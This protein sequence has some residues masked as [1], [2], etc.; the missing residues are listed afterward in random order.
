MRRRRLLALIAAL[1]AAGAAHASLPHIAP[2]MPGARAA[3]H[4]TFTWFGMKIYDAT[5]WVGEAGYAAGAPFALELRYARP[6]Q[7]ARIA[8]ASADQMEKTGGGTAAQRA[9]WHRQMHAIFPDVKQ[10][11]SITGLF[12]PNGAVRFHHDGAALGVISDP[13]FAQ[14]FAGIWLSP[15]TTAPRLREA[16]LKGAARR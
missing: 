5:L 1:V 3:G 2:E 10:G 9:A 14:A 13:G 8:Q 6:L 16:L 11:S 7:G 15:R 4:G 12:L